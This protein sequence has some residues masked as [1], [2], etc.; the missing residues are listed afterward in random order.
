MRIVLRKGQVLGPI[1]VASVR[2]MTKLP[3]TAFSEDKIKEIHVSHISGIERA[4]F[5]LAGKNRRLFDPF[6]KLLKRGKYRNLQNLKILRADKKR[7]DEF[8]D[9]NKLGEW[10]IIEKA[11]EMTPEPQGNTLEEFKKE[12]ELSYNDIRENWA[13]YIYY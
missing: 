5:I 6:A 7:I 4:R 9:K 12:Y 8:A 3:I 13:A 1:K 2:G 11:Q 10:I